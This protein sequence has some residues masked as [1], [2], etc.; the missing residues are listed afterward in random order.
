MTTVDSA[1]V[2]RRRP[3]A[4]RRHRSIVRRVFYLM[5]ARV[6]R[7]PARLPVAH[8]QERRRRGRAAAVRLERRAHLVHDID[9]ARVVR[10]LPSSSSPRGQP[11]TSSPVAARTARL[12][13]VGGG[14]AC[15]LS[16]SPLA[17]AR[18]HSGRGVGRD[19]GKV[20][21]RVLED[22]EGG[23]ARCLSLLLSSSS[24][25]R[26]LRHD[27]RHRAGARVVF[28]HRAERAA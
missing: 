23:G 26:H 28:D 27:D 25:R 6:A 2:R 21:A 10:V 24:E 22:E 16:S 4:R 3:H 20:G 1:F 11:V 8:V 15:V 13:A 14:A 7:Q 19:I 5:V 12:S 17:R 9:D 18:R